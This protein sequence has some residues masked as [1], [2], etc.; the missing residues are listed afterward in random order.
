VDAKFVTENEGLKGFY[1]YVDAYR[2]LADHLSSVVFANGS[3]KR[4][5][6]RPITIE[7]KKQGT[8]WT[9]LAHSRVDQLKKEVTELERQLQKQ[10]QELKKANVT[11]Q[12]L[13]ANVM[14]FFHHPDNFHERNYSLT[15]TGFNSAKLLCKDGA[16]SII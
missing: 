6:E 3:L 13:L 16:P 5:G 14:P 4:G 12:A 1:N 2:Y 9:R 11:I 7:L 15:K 10:E 8:D